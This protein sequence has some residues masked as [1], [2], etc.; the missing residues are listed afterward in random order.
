MHHNGGVTPFSDMINHLQRSNFATNGNGNGNGNGSGPFSSSPPFPLYPPVNGMSLPPIS[1]ATVTNGIGA[2]TTTTPGRSMSIDDVNNNNNNNYNMTIN[3]NDNDNEEDDEY[4]E[5]NDNDDDDASSTTSTSTGAGTATGSTGSKG[6]RSST[7]IVWTPF[8]DQVLK[9]AVDEYNHRNWKKVAERLPGRTEVQCHH[10]YQKLMMTITVKGSW[11]RE[12]DEL[13]KKLVNIYGPKKWSEI[14]LHLKGRLGKQCRERWHNHLN[15]NIKRDAWTEEEDRIIGEKHAEYGNK[16]AE[17]AK[18]LPGRTDNAIK[19]HYNSSMKRTKKGQ[20]QDAR[21]NNKKDNSTK[22]RKSTSTSE[23]GHH[24]ANPSVGNDPHPMGDPL[25]LDIASLQQYIL[26]GNSPKSMP[27]APSPLKL[28]FNTPGH[29]NNSHNYVTGQHVDLHQLV[30][31]IKLYSNS[32]LLKKKAKIDFSPSKQTP[33]HQQQHQLHQQQQQ[34]PDNSIF[35]SPIQR[36]HDRS[37]MAADI[38]EFSPFKSMFGTPSGSGQVY[39][40]DPM[41]TAMFSPYKSPIHH[42]QQQHQ[43]YSPLYHL[44]HNNGLLSSSSSSPS[45]KSRHQL[46]TP[47][48]LHVLPTPTWSNNTSGSNANNNGILNGDMDAHRS[49]LG[50]HMTDRG[51]DKNQLSTINSKLRGE[52]NYNNISGLNDNYFVPMTPFKDTTSSFVD[53]LSLSDIGSMRSSILSTPGSSRDKSRMSNKP[54]LPL[55]F[56][57]SSNNSSCVSG[58]ASSTSFTM[59]DQSSLYIMESNNNISNIS[60]NS[61]NLSLIQHTTTT[62]NSND[63]SF[64]ALRRLSNDSKQSI[65]NK[66]RRI[67]ESTN[68]T[69]RSQDRI[70]ISDIQV[71]YTPISTSHHYLVTPITK[72]PFP[73]NTIATVS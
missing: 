4:Y 26:S 25:S 49:K 72:V 30:S 15:P 61:N 35:Y 45:P 65:F 44:P 27:K 68:D 70:N 1:M 54:H 2:A 6:K 36:A 59:D 37:T 50:I 51:V 38:S 43:Q 29:G 39:D 11:T 21:T 47:S 67:L 22:K 55:S 56:S 7:R 42:Q 24:Q 63:C 3:D 31:P 10:R 64:E 17:I 60:N 23:D 62:S 18:F 34:Y 58:P 57:S 66:A 12:E 19:N 73:T 16:W 20:R 53:S 48:S 69:N 40:Y 9:Q 41:K 33:E 52:P 71:P 28:V 32:G 14:A 5:D 46:P 8:D 13:I